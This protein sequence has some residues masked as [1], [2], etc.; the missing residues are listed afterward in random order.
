VVTYSHCK[1]E[2]FNPNSDE[3]VRVHLSRLGVELEKETK[4][5]KL[6]V[7]KFVL[8]DLAGNPDPRVSEFVSA[9]IELNQYST[10]ESTFL[11]N[12]ESKRDLHGRLR[13]SFNQCVTLTGRLSSSN[14]NLQNI[15]ARGELGDMMRSL[16]V[17]PPGYK[18]ISID[19]SNIEGRVVAHYLSKVMRDSRME[20]TFRSGVDFH[21]ANQKDW[22]LDT[23]AQAKTLLYAFIYGA[24]A[25]KLGGGNKEVG[26]E[27]IRRLEVN[28]P[29]L[30]DLKTTIIQEA[31]KRRQPFVRTLYGR[32]L[33]YPD[34]TTRDFKLRARAERQVVNALIQGSAADIL[35]HLLIQAVPIIH[36][37]GGTLLLQV[38][39]ELVMEVPTESARL[40]AD[41]L[42]AL[43]EECLLLT[44]C[45]IAG[46]AKI[47]DNWN[48]VH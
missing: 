32:R 39:D 2:E 27:L 9:M 12:F 3:H 15:P 48:E 16:V 22:G 44:H 5:G 41:A 25:V 6:S 28:M 8:A 10:V 33:Y 42:T 19:L 43:F 14:P 17:A 31:K 29:A 4:T 7:D 45:P 23:R 20:Q 13:C 47:G 37:Y 11:N 38:H 18:L 36:K 24:S 21:S 26:L 1:L 30:L 40:L 46:E 35:K 34:L